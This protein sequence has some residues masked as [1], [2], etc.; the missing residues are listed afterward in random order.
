MVEEFESQLE[1]TVE[2][3]FDKTYRVE[4]YELSNGFWYVI[5]LLINPMCY[6]YYLLYEHFFLNDY[7]DFSHVISLVVWVR[8]ISFIFV[9]ILSNNKNINAA[10]FLILT[11]IFPLAPVLILNIMQK[12]IFPPKYQNYADDAKC[13]L[14][15]KHAKNLFY[16]NYWTESLFFCNKAL[17]LKSENDRE[18]NDIINL[19]GLWYKRLGHL[20]KAINCFSL[21]LSKTDSS[22]SGEYYSNRGDVYYKLKDY[23]KAKEDWEMAA[24]PGNGYRIEWQSI[25]EKINSLEFID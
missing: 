22:F 19:K 8:I 12:R 1:D 6:S 4:H 16:S 7:I 18:L 25:E 17:E 3:V 24:K 21:A 20:D 23:N 10:L 13:K 2:Q 14:L 9:L 5:I 11:I 15:H